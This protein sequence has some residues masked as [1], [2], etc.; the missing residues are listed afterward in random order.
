MPR[1]HAFCA[2][3]RQRNE[4]GTDR[5]KLGVFLKVKKKKKNIQQLKN[6][7]GGG[8]GG[9]AHNVF[10]VPTT[11]SLHN[12]SNTTQFDDLHHKQYV[13]VFFFTMLPKQII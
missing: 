5:S 9:G 12:L 13:R 11:I 3:P 10:F 1:R 7:G 2:C 6:A 4:L 8:E